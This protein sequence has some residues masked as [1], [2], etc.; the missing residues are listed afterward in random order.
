MHLVWIFHHLRESFKFVHERH[1]SE[2]VHLWSFS[3]RLFRGPPRAVQAVKGGQQREANS[4]WDVGFHPSLSLQ[5]VAK[6]SIVIQ[7]L[8]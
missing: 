3:D 5:S 4:N 8:T 1:A 7:T 6:V 2:L